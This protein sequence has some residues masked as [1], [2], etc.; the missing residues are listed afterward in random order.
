MMK[1]QNSNAIGSN[2]AV[3]DDKNARSNDLAIVGIGCRF[4]GDANN[5]R[6]FWENLVAGL[7]SISETPESRW[8]IDNFYH[9][10]T[11]VVAKSATKWGGFI[12]DIDRFDAEFF[13]ISPR[14]ARLMDPQQR[15]LLEVCWEALEDA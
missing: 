7:D 11:G 12:K 5:P 9:P 2:E 15:L 8:A 10:K 6:Q 14:E 3:V 4:P 1:K 13:N